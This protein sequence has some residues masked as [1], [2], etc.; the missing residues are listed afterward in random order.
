M[1]ATT[2]AIASPS[3]PIS[4]SSAVSPETLLLNGVTI[5]GST[6]SPDVIEL[7]RVVNE[8]LKVWNDTGTFVDIPEDQWMKIPLRDD[9]E[10]KM[11]AR[12]PR[13][14]PLGIEDRKHIDKT[15]D[16]L[17]EKERMS[18]ST[19]STPFSYPV[20]V[21]WKTLPSGERKGRVVIDIRGLNQISRIDVYPL[22]LQSD[23]IAAV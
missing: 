6:N 19:T 8:F 10:S 14:Y 16:K 5:Y 22:P 18:W 3:N 7:T 13:V 11:P 20:F 21:V 15:F 9:W 17:Y 23:I 12:A 1:L 4:S 2:Y